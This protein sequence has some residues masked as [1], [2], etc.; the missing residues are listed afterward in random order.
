MSVNVRGSRWRRRRGGR[1]RLRGRR[2]RRRRRRGRRLRR[3]GRRERRLRDPARRDRAREL[4]RA[5]PTDVSSAAARTAFVRSLHDRVAILLRLGH[6]A[7]DHGVEPG[8]EVGPLRGQPRRRLDEVRVDERRLGRRLERRLAAEALVEHAAERVEVGAAVDR[9]AL[10]L[11]GGGV[12]ERADEEARLRQ[13]RRGHLLRDPE[14]AQVDALRRL[15]DED[16]RRLDV[17]VDEPAVVRRVERARDLLQQVERLPEPERPLLLQQR[18]QVDAL[19]VAHGDVEEAVRLAR[20]V[21]RDDVRVVERGGDLRLADEALAEGVVAGQRRRHQLERDLPPQLHVLGL[22]DDAHAAA[23]DH[24]RDPVAGELRACG[25]VPA[26]VRAHAACLPGPT[27]RRVVL[28]SYLRPRG[29]LRAARG[30]KSP[31]RPSCGRLPWSP[32]RRHEGAVR[33][34]AT[35]AAPSG[36]RCARRRM[37]H[38][39][40][41]S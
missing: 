39:V 9:L 19:D 5:R 16:V 22:V 25:H 13:T 7:R 12:L 10:E 15:R 37:C 24:V 1:G 2:L 8:G 29:P 26:H 34:A 33:L 35:I 23:A 3:L 18:A 30:R 6:R 28:R 17:P 27:V 41:K 31:R 14:V 20:V 40:R 38:R 21:D 11:L 36:R 4:G 32:L